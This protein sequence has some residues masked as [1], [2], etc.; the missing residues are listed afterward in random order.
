MGKQDR[1]NELFERIEG[2]K[3]VLKLTGNRFV[4]QVRIGDFI[5]GR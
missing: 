5:H 4:A 2:R 1:L 3:V